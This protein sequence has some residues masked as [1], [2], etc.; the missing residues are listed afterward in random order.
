[1]IPSNKKPCPAATGAGLYQDSQTQINSV[2]NQEPQSLLPL[3]LRVCAT[4]EA[5]A[6]WQGGRVGECRA[7]PAVMVPTFEHGRGWPLSGPDDWCLQHRQ[8]IAQ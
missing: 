8:R 4:C 3:P 2:P 7:Y 6:P 5:W 1:M